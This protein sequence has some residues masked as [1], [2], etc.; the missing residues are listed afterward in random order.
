MA[1]IF[2]YS[3]WRLSFLPLLILSITVNFALSRF[4]RNA[5][6][7]GFLYLGIVFN[8]ALL[9]YFKYLGFFKG[10]FSSFQSSGIGDPHV[11]LPLGIS[12]YT[13][14]QISFLVDS[15]RDRSIDYRLRDYALFV[16]FFPQLIA[17]PILH[18]AE[19]MPQLRDPFAQEFSTENF[20]RGLSLFSLGLFQKVVLADS[21]APLVNAGFAARES[22]SFIEAW[23]TAL[24]FTFQLYFDLFR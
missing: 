8:L 22:L 1:S 11:L 10:F 3:Y 5:R 18:H 19:F 15:W 23:A 2:F 17:G 24:G 20:L 9:F 21:L 7:P 16:T 13:F 14:Q 4:I 6:N 12:F